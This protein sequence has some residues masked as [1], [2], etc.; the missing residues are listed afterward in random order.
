[1]ALGTLVAAVTVGVVL[2]VVLSS[3]TRLTAQPDVFMAYKGNQ[4]RFSVLE[5]DV[6]ESNSTLRVLRV[7]QPM[8]G[9]AEIAPTNDAIIYWASQRFSGEDPFTYTVANEEGYESTGQVNVTVMN[10]PPKAQELVALD[11]PNNIMNFEL[12]LF[13]LTNAQDEAITDPDMDSLTIESISSPMYGNAT[14]VDKEKGIVRYTSAI[15]FNGI[16]M[17]EYTV[18]DGNDTVL[19][20][21]FLS[22]ANL[23]PTVPKNAIEFKNL[24]KDILQELHILD[25]VRDPNG[26]DVWISGID[27]I[28]CEGASLVVRP[29]VQDGQ[30]IEFIPTKAE[31]LLQPNADSLTTVRRGCTFSFTAT[32]GSL[33]SNGTV[34]VSLKNELPEVM[35]KHFTVSKGEPVILQIIPFD[36][37][38]YDSV[39]L[40]LNDEGSSRD[41]HL[42]LRK[43]GEAKVTSHTRPAIRDSVMTKET[44]YVLHYTPQ[45][46]VYK[47]TVMLRAHDGYDFHNVM[48]TIDVVNRPPVATD[49]NMNILCKKNIGCSM[50]VLHGD[51]DPDG[52]TLSVEANNAPLLNMMGMSNSDGEVIVK[53]DNHVTFIPPS[54]FVGETSFSY[55][56]SDKKSNPDGYEMLSNPAFVTL[57][58]TNQAPIAVDQTF[59][60]VRRGSG[61]FDVVAQSTDPNNDELTISRIEAPSL[62]S[63]GSSAT[64]SNDGKSIIYQAPIDGHVATDSVL[65]WVKDTDE[66]ESE[67]P[68]RMEVVITNRAPI[69]TNFPAVQFVHWRIPE[70]SEVLFDTTPHVSDP[71]GDSLTITNLDYDQESFI[72]TVSEDNP[73]AFK[74]RPKPSVVLFIFQFGFTVSDGY[75]SATGTMRL[76]V[77]NTRPVALNYDAGDIFHHVITCINP[78]GDSYDPDNDPIHLN[79]VDIPQLG[80]AV[81]SSNEDGPCIN[82][83]GQIQG[84]ES[85]RFTIS[86]TKDAT[87]AY[88]SFNVVNSPPVAVDDEISVHWR[89][90]LREK[91][92]SIQAT[93][94]DYD[95]DE[96]TVAIIDA[97]IVSG[98]G[99]LLYSFT[100]LELTLPDELPSEWLSTSVRETIVSYT[101][102]DHSATSTALATFRFTNDHKPQPSVTS[103]V[104]HWRRSQNLEMDPLGSSHDDDGDLLE[105]CPDNGSS[106]ACPQS[107]EKYGSTVTMLT[108]NNRSQISYIANQPFVTDENE[109]DVV[110]TVV[111]D[112]L[113][114]A[115]IAFDIVSYNSK[116]VIHGPFIS[117]YNFL[118]FGFQVGFPSLMKNV[119]D[120]DEEDRSHLKLL[121]CAVTTPFGP[122]SVAAID[123]DGTG[124]VYSADDCNADNG[125]KIEI[126]VTDGFDITTGEIHV[127]CNKE[128]VDV[129]F[130]DHWR[131]LQNSGKEYEILQRL[132]DTK[133]IP[134]GIVATSI[135]SDPN[136]GVSEIISPSTLRYAQTDVCLNEQTTLISI[137]GDYRDIPVTITVTNTPP[138]C[139]A[140]YSSYH[141]RIAREDPIHFAL[142]SL[143]SD[144]NDDPIEI[145][146]PSASSIV[147]TA[148]G[149]VTTNAENNEIVYQLTQDAMGQDSFTFEVT[150]SVEECNATIHIT[151]TNNRPNVHHLVERV[152]WRQILGNTVSV[153]VL[154]GVSDPDDDPVFLV[155][156]SING[157]DDSFATLTRVGS[158]FSIS[159]TGA[160]MLNTVNRQHHRVNFNITDKVSN[161]PGSVRFEVNNEAP[162]ASNITNIDV[163]AYTRL[164]GGVDIPLLHH[165]T[166]AD[167]ADREFLVVS[168]VTLVVGQ[169]IVEK[170]SDQQSL[171]YTPGDNVGVEQNVVVK[172]RITDGVEFSDWAEV[173]IR[174]R[175]TAPEANHFEMEIEGHVESPVP[176]FNIV[177]RGCTDVDVSNG[178]DLKQSF[179]FTDIE[180]TGP[181]FGTLKNLGHGDVSFTPTTN[182]GNEAFDE[183]NHVSQVFRFICRD[184]AGATAS[185]NMTIKIHSIKPTALP[186]E[187][188][189]IRNGQGQEVL[190]N[191]FTDGGVERVQDTVT[192]HLQDAWKNSTVGRIVYNV[193]GNILFTPSGLG[194]KTAKIMMGYKITNGQRT[195]ESTYT[196]TYENKA[197]SC[198]PTSHH[199]I[200]RKAV[201][202]EIVV[203]DFIIATDANNDPIVFDLSNVQDENLIVDVD[204]DRA[205][206][207]HV[208]T[209]PKKSGPMTYLVE[210]YDDAGDGDSC[211][212]VIEAENRAPVANDVDMGEYE[213]KSVIS[214]IILHTNASDPDDGDSIKVH[215][216]TLSANCAGQIILNQDD[217]IRF[218]AAPGQD[219]V[220]QITYSVIDDDEQNPLTSKPATIT[221][222]FFGS[223]PEARD[224]VFH[225]SQGKTRI[226][227]ISELLFN[228]TSPNDQTLVFDEEFFQ[229]EACS[230]ADLCTGGT[231]PTLVNNQIHYTA[232]NANC[233][234]D[235][236]VYR[237]KTFRENSD[238]TEENVRY[239][240]VATVT[241]KLQDC[242]CQE[243]MDVI[244]VLDGSGSIS[245]TNW[246]RMRRFTWNLAHQFKVGCNDV[247]I[248]VVQFGTKATSSLL[249]GFPLM[250]NLLAIGTRLLFMFQMNGG[251][252]TRGGLRAAI[253]MFEKQ[254]RHNAKKVVVV[255]TDGDANLPCWCGGSYERPYGLGYYPG[256]NSNNNDGRFTGLG[257]EHKNAQGDWVCNWIGQQKWNMTWDEEHVP[258]HQCSPWTSCHPCAD[259]SYEADYLKNELQAKVVAFGVGPEIT[260]I[261][262]RYIRDM[263]FQEEYIHSSFDS[264][265]GMYNI[266]ADHS[267]AKEGN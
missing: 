96:D 245:K 199:P 121:S 170:G 166:D 223:D 50:Y 165:M 91:V 120:D 31:S 190:F 252:N 69:A 161:S 133:I 82:Y 237:V 40:E 224:D 222:S 220:C 3:G 250:D 10:I 84:R 111:S 228:D 16:D 196:L 201:K 127:Q 235:K 18:S 65:F 173:H 198:V 185:A 248:G 126:R 131:T 172:Y 27:I 153:D 219:G 11:V 116:P 211:T 94:N 48:I 249:F 54:G 105:L 132:K 28:D 71:D 76:I 150:D 225:V 103:I 141:W 205:G 215:S 256:C 128:S 143:A 72:V 107:L 180:P 134:D 262:Q 240:N 239:S 259:P 22:V 176:I 39:T 206:V 117:T 169:G 60:V 155:E 26:D 43:H 140:Q 151:L 46:T 93:K 34:F 73:L 63:Y 221:I 92:I 258:C 98:V 157:W 189:V 4:F 138:Q 89:E 156:D 232:S 100:K 246:K 244:M 202:Q 33:S 243:A 55:H 231:R 174:V 41:P 77:S 216:A 88:L 136:C 234:S 109:P 19:S 8:Y 253:E 56:V 44:N 137:S 110:T 79:A 265:E 6:N 62:S 266:I 251:T 122:G 99:Q 241:M 20:S 193:D 218:D 80:T 57:S 74:V 101:I 168:H 7:S 38:T 200:I 58:V 186:L 152:H 24:K 227:E 267:C 17:L 247:R 42:A 142:P 147:H 148:F 81:M 49:K 181:T 21:M 1:M 159:Q 25:H 242:V 263:H 135:V 195:T 90:A 208:T 179:R 83:Y 146:S 47:D 203:T 86:D 97:H 14:L 35:E 106:N 36:Q 183:N 87:V 114:T 261:G 139:H 37:D 210:V 119:T 233:D 226:I 149:Q 102:T 162:V 64:I 187:M 29:S 112:G 115:V 192:I 184:A 158:V 45:N 108:Q 191:V 229:T 213:T 67:Q 85:V 167:E 130:S 254:P 145:S 257:S 217:K 154:Q 12:N 175:N 118:Q 182:I 238:G 32:D 78:V 188:S 171:H 207:I 23:P 194:K 53:D 2:A 144:S 197:P 51:S 9:R 125:G 30:F 236:F 230:G 13:A 264:L 178:D 212:L 104:K 129:E 5:N 123:A 52:D 70:G 66:A 75:A 260:P 59:S 160:N 204:E 164:T 61:T 177:D 68:G 113:D 124:C 255:L 209:S 214:T 15:D 163:W 95:P